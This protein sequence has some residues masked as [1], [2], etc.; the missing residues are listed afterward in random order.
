MTSFYTQT[1]PDTVGTFLYK[2]TFLTCLDLGQVF[3]VTITLADML[4][5]TRLIWVFKKTGF[6]S[7]D[8]LG[9]LY[10]QIWLSSLLSHVLHALAVRELPGRK[11][12]VV[13][14]I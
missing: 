12:D 5:I 6:L 14:L 9:L 8:K 11:H 3:F 7:Q 4:A 10:R 1:N 2:R 13:G